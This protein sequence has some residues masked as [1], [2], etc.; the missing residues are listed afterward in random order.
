MIVN[1]GGRGVGVGSAISQM[2]PLLFC[3]TDSQHTHSDIQ[4]HTQL[5]KQSV[6]VRQNK[7]KMQ[8]GERENGAYARVCVCVSRWGRKQ[9]VC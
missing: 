2:H 3:L 8:W 9:G 6:I 7:T 4:I 5:K 1:T